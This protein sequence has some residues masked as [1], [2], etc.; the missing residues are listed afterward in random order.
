METSC[1]ISFVASGLPP[2]CSTESGMRMGVAC[3]PAV[4]IACNPK[5]AWRCAASRVVVQREE[6]AEEQLVQAL[7]LDALPLIQRRRAALIRLADGVHRPMKVTLTWSVWYTVQAV[8]ASSTGRLQVRHA[9]AISTPPGVIA[10]VAVGGGG[11]PLR[12]LSRA[13][14]QVGQGRSSRFLLGLLP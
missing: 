1:D 5:R 13:Q 4:E 6:G 3:M 11:S 2:A 9:D 8:L 7:Q 10:F 12:V 14:A